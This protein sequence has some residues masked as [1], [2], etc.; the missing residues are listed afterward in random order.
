MNFL[1]EHGISS[2]EELIERCDA[3][4]AASI[5]TRE[6]LRIP[7]SRSPTLPSWESNRHIPKAEARL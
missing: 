1:T 6:S 4:A 3:I 2:Y 5:R 7:N